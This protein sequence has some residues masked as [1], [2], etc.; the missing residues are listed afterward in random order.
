MKK[1]DFSNTGRKIEK[2]CKIFLFPLFFFSILSLCGAEKD[3]L[4]VRT[5]KAEKKEKKKSGNFWRNNFRGAR[6]KAL[7]ENK[8]L[9]LFFTVS[10]APSG[11][12]PA[13]IARY[14]YNKN[15]M[16]RAGKDHILVHI[17][18][19]RDK[20]NLSHAHRKQN[21]QLFSRF[22][23]I[24]FPTFILLDPRTPWGAVLCRRTGVFSPDI[25]LDDLEKRAS[26][27]YK[28]IRKAGKKANPPAA[29]AEEAKEK[30]KR[31]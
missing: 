4:A 25:L 22:S 28:R 8:F 16:E 2:Y 11:N 31:K 9:L 10:D 20:Y 29:E 26:G 12:A 5:E 27:H 18:L 21:E 17:D 19:P 6:K 7:Q 14:K 15:F 30:E 13:V 23:V 1:T 3:L 24:H